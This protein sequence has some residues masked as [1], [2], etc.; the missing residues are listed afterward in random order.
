MYWP[1]R[2]L[3]WLLLRT[4]F[5]LRVISAERI[6]ATGPLVVVANHESFL[7][8]PVVGAALRHR[9]ATFLSAPWLFRVPVVGVFLRSIGSL[10]A[11]SG[12]GEVATLREAI[13][14]LE[15]GGTVVVFPQGGI[16]GSQFYGGAVFLAVKAEAPLLPMRIVGTKEALPLGRRWPSFFS[17]VTVRIGTPIAAEDLSPPGSPTGVAVAQGRR[18][19]EELL[20]L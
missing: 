17:P 4:F 18:L 12:R 16:S 6:P 7:D 5:G 15:R 13:R 2:F 14:I 9:K 20:T 3:G 8:G 19:L 1:A 11:H 10:P